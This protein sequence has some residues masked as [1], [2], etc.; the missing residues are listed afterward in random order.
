MKRVMLVIL[1]LAGLPPIMAAA[2]AQTSSP[3]SKPTA[4]A[5]SKK[6]EALFTDAEIPFTKTKGGYYVAVVTVGDESDRFTASVDT[7]GNDPNNPVLQLGTIIFSIGEL[8]KGVQ[9][10]TQLAKQI[11][12]WNSDLSVGKIIQIDDDFYY[13]STLWLDHTDGNALSREAIIG[14]LNA[15]NL[16]KELLPYLKQ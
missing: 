8:P 15:K 16:R 1:F 11:I 3:A 7:L 10:P 5:P 6:L 2:T 12:Q 14:H 9:I 13:V 4:D